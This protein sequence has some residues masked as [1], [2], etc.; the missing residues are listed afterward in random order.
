MTFALPGADRHALTA[1]VVEPRRTT[2]PVRD[3]KDDARDCDWPRYASA[4]FGTIRS[5]AYLAW[6]YRAHPAFRYDVLACGAEG[7]AAIA[8]VRVEPVSG[9]PASVLRVVEFF[10][11]DDETGRADAAALLDALLTRARTAHCAFVEWTGT[12]AASTA[13]FERAGWTREIPDAELLPGRFRPPE[14]HA[15]R[16]NLEVGVAPGLAQPPLEALHVTRGDGDADRAGSVG[17]LEGVS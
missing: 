7:R 9:T 11:P 8:V 4:A 17:D 6:R 2:I 15:F 14:R 3:P 13:T 12:S 1:A 10:H 16:L 5:R